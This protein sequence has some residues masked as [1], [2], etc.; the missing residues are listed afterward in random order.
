[1]S[2]VC[3]E[4]SV[5]KQARL[6][7]RFTVS[8]CRTDDEVAECQ[9]LRYRVFV[10]ELGARVRCQRTGYE[11]DGFDPYCKHLVVRDQTSGEA[12]ATARLLLD[13]QASCVG[14]FY[15]ETEFDL[16]RVRK[17]RGRRMEVGRSCI[18]AEYRRGSAL[19]TLWQG[20]GRMV[21]L[22]AIDYL[23]GCV[24]I[25]LNLKPGYAAA[26]IAE[27]H[28]RQRVL[29][30]ELAVVPRR[31]LPPVNVAES[32]F[33][34]ASLPVLLKGYLQQ[35]ALVGGEPC[36]DPDFNVADL[37]VLLDRDRLSPRYAR[38]FLRQA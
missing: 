22:H 2:L 11:S 26:V 6:A 1:M 14:Q 21:E 28:R 15:S 3:V 20:I 25:P 32:Q 37:F 24:S 31:A 36:W 13:S 29:P 17:L 8:L 27:I 7:R 19:S 18:L 10:Q 33:S 30:P 12:V 23:F 38:R 9:R 35:G 4:D 16:S 5:V 34:S